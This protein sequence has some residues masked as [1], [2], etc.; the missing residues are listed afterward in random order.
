[1]SQQDFDNFKH[2]L[3]N[4]KET[5]PEEYESL[6]VRV[7]GYSGYFVDLCPDVQDDI[8]ARTEHAL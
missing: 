7:A 2:R 5:H 8:I 1:M 3:K 4:W 6:I